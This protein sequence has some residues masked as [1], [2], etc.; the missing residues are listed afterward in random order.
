[1]AVDFRQSK[2]VNHILSCI[3]SLVV[4]AFSRELRKVKMIV[5]LR[6]KD[7]ATRLKRSDRSVSR[8]CI[9]GAYSIQSVVQKSQPLGLEDARSSSANCSLNRALAHIG[10]GSNNNLDRAG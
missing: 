5:Q 3:S 6:V 7:D 10:S 4:S 9:L 1:M 8:L 2:L